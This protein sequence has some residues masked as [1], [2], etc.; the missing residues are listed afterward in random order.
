MKPDNLK[1]QFAQ[2]EIQPSAQ[3][4]E[5]LNA[6][7]DAE[8][9]KGRFRSFFYWTG[10]VAA[11]FILLLAGYLSLQDTRTT[12]IAPATVVFEE[13]DIEKGET[14]DRKILTA[15][16]ESKK[17]VDKEISKPVQKQTKKSTT[18]EVLLAETKPVKKDKIDLK[19]AA[20]VENEVTIAEVATGDQNL[21]IE[22]VEESQSAEADILLAEALAEL[23]TEQFKETKY[24]LT[25]QQLL[26]EAEWDIEQDRRTQLQ[27]SLEN[28]LNGAAQ[29]AL[30]FIGIG[31]E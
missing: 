29:D 22:N 5:K 27:Q 7:L 8:K 14:I 26:R 20:M 21:E 2:R 19:R 4:W 13:P 17:S 12:R 25:A 30:A 24:T 18:T 1:E 10:S 3:A 11:G 28:T 31:R 23:E 9:T 16:Q 6:K 15:D